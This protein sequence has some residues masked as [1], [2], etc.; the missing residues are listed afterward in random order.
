M[1]YTRQRFISIPGLLP[2][3]FPPFPDALTHTPWPCVSHSNGQILI[4][5]DLPRPVEIS[6]TLTPVRN[7]ELCTGECAYGFYVCQRCSSASHRCAIT[8]VEACISAAPHRT[9]DATAVGF[10]S[11]I[12]A[13]IRGRMNLRQAVLKCPSLRRA[14][15]SG[16][17][18]AA[19]LL[20]NATLEH[21]PRHPSVHTHAETL[22]HLCTQTQASLRL[23]AERAENEPITQTFSPRAVP[24]R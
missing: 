15:N 1:F 3:S 21:S 7:L 9:K 8:E 12:S 19:S 10:T 23:P 6:S 4:L 17:T 18:P 13:D 20:M 5:R 14:D 22:T 16:R 11:T 24:A 2:P